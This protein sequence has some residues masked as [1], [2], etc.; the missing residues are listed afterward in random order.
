MAIF[1]NQATLV[2]NGGSANSNI[3]VGEILEVLSADKTAVSGT[4]TP[5]ELS[6]ASP[7]LTI[8]AA[9]PMRP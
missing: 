5:G 9:G 4:Y 7:S 3:A 8:W 2:Y 1:T 6:R